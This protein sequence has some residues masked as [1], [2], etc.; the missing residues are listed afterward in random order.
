MS[1]VLVIFA[2]APVV[3][4]VKTRLCPPLTLGQA[5]ELARCFLL[6]TVEQAC[7]LS[8]DVQVF[9]A[10]TPT[11]S[12]PLF[13]ALLPFPVQYLAQRGSSLGE[14]ECNVFLDL[15]QRG[16]KKVILIGSDIP[17]LPET[18]LQ[19]AFTLLEDPSCDVVLNP[20]TDGGYC[21]IG[22]REPHTA[23]F[24]NIAWSTPAVMQETLVQAQ[25]DHLSVRL[26]PS[27]HDVDDESDL[28]RLG[29]ELSQQDEASGAVRTRSM[30]EQLGFCLVR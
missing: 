30:L 27:W 24:E 9:I 10:F 18:H 20:T 5:A 29:T 14:R 8:A 19:E 6:D 13:R 25:R 21:L 22:M 16:A 17:T 1:N 28:R 15:H 26:L 3:G 2:K 12:E 11:G 23:L 7:S 4:Q